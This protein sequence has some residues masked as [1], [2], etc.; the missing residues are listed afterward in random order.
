MAALQSAV[1]IEWVAVP[2]AVEGESILVLHRPIEHS[3]G[4]SRSPRLP[5]DSFAACG[6]C[7]SALSAAGAPA[8]RGR[9][10][11]ATA[12]AQPVRWRH[13]ARRAGGGARATQLAKSAAGGRAGAR[14]AGGG[15]AARGV[16]RNMGAPRA[17]R[18]RLTHVT[19]ACA[20]PGA[21]RGAPCRMQ[22]GLRPRGG[23]DLPL[24]R[25]PSARLPPAALSRATR[26]LRW[27]TRRIRR[28]VSGRRRRWWPGAR[29][30]GA[31]LQGPLLAALGACAAWVALCCAAA[32][33][34]RCGDAG[35]VRAG[36][37]TNG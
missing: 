6:Q 12:M 32:L 35:L 25:S 30:T 22:R 24:T 23:T 3:P 11:E 10:E 20:N 15:A 9:G 4:A 28:T 7:C 36:T 2:D 16:A 8:R 33:G 37:A 19:S 27:W 31:R 18:G 5:L 1:G 34:V 14:R 17:A 13:A 21:P 29:G 26:T